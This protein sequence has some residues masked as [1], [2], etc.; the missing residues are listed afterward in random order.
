VKPNPER[1][2]GAREERAAIRKIIRKRMNAVVNDGD[3]WSEIY[4]AM[5]FL[6]NEITARA[7]RTGKRKGGT[8]RI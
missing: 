8:G 4:S 3:A 5:Q 6:L 2:A 1:N 7:K